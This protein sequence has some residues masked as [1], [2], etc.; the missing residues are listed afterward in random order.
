MNMS[1]HASLMVGAFPFMGRAIIMLAD[2][3][4]LQEPIGRAIN[5]KPLYTN[6]SLSHNKVNK[7][8]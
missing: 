4:G 7:K 8:T 1:L 3:G 5:M 6:N 2:N